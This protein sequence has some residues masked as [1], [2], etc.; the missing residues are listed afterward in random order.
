MSL[1]SAHFIWGVATPRDALLNLLHSLSS[2][3]LLDSGLELG[4]SVWLSQ[5]P[6]FSTLSKLLETGKWSQALELLEQCC[7]SP[8]GSARR[9][10]F[11]LYFRLI[12]PAKLPE[13]PRAR[14]EALGFIA[15]DVDP[16]SLL[17]P[18]EAWV[19]FDPDD[20]IGSKAAE[21]ALSTVSWRDLETFVVPVWRLQKTPSSRPAETPAFSSALHLRMGVDDARYLAFILNHAGVWTQKHPLLFEVDE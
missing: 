5:H 21:K 6:Q 8:N 19:T 12:P 15:T 16:N 10:P 9:E 20:W 3:G 13:E 18:Y 11:H 17:A 2:Q 1:E 14:W 4:E 7:A